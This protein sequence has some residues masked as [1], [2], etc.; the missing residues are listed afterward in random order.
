VIDLKL[1]PRN[2]ALSR[3]SN[4]PEQCATV[5]AAATEKDGVFTHTVLSPYQEGETRIQVLLPERRDHSDLRRVVYLLPVEPHDGRAWGDAMAEILARDLHNQHQL[6]FAMPTF[7]HAPWYA[8]HASDPQIRQESHFLKVVMPFVESTYPVRVDAT[9]RLLLGFSKSG[10]GAYSLLLRHPDVF[11][12]AAAWD[13][14]LGQ[15]SPNKYGMS[16]VF[17]TQESLDRFSIWELLK[18][19]AA[20]LAGEPRLALLGYGDFRGHHQATHYH[21]LK[22]GIPH[23]YQDG[24][25]RDHHWQSGWVTDAVKFLASDTFASS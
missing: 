3:M 1:L 19:R 12:K 5:S 7:S 14:P 6:I 18:A 16:A 23:E 25:R 10:W 13:A 11:W 24:P 21:M 17:A 15:A 22:L 2:R 8:D 9:G 4:K 20:L